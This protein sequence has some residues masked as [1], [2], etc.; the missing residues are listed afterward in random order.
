M[1]RLTLCLS[2][3]FVS[4]AGGSVFAEQT[5]EAFLETI[6]AKSRASLTVRNLDELNTQNRKHLQRDQAF[7]FK[8][9]V[10][11]GLSF[12]KIQ[13]GVDWSGTFSLSMMSLEQSDD[14]EVMM[15][16]LVL[17]VPFTD[18]ET[19]A[20][21][22]TLSKEEI[23]ARKYHFFG[24]RLN[25]FGDL[26]VTF[27]ERDLL[28]SMQQEAIEQYLESPAMS[29]VVATDPGGRLSGSDLL[30]Q[31]NPRSLDPTQYDRQTEKWIDQM[32]QGETEEHRELAKQVVR[33][34][35]QVFC[36]MK[37]E[38]GV[39]L[40]FHCNLSPDLSEEVKSALEKYHHSSSIPDLRGIPK[41]N[42]LL[43]LSKAADREQ[44][45]ALQSRATAWMVERMVQ[46]KSISNLILPYLDPRSDTFHG[47]IDEIWDSIDEARSAVY[48]NENLKED[49]LGNLL[50]ILKPESHE[51]FTEQLSSLVKFSR[52]AVYHPDIRQPDKVTEQDIR[53]LIAQLG[54][55]EFL[56][57][58]AAML[59]LKL[60]GEPALPL[61]EQS[62]NSR[63]K[64]IARRSKSLVISIRENAAHH[65]EVLIKE[66]LTALP[67]PEFVFY[68]HQREIAGYPADVLVAQWD[69]SDQLN[70]KRVQELAGPQGHEILIVHVKNEIVLF[71]GSDRQLL[72]DCLQLLKSG[73]PGLDEQR[74]T[75]AKY[76]APQRLFEAHFSMQKLARM[77][78]EA[79][80]RPLPESDPTGDYSS[81]GVEISPQH[82]IGDVSLP[83]P[84]FLLMARYFFLF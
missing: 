45:A 26:Y 32:F 21:N 80:G 38:N 17:R 37:I 23:A 30:L 8:Q 83:L 16:Q 58:K 50:V 29:T 62:V 61:L 39:Q 71:W 52:G 5:P 60:L 25:N 78:P 1:L 48:L 70:L 35:N 9:L 81:F 73:E 46:Q 41:G 53:D 75:F 69:E 43:G 36:S 28:I 65:A 66:G 27:R 6:P 77:V 64:E 63:D 59:R 10:Q 12:M 13:Q 19:M 24:K 55:Q 2:L 47:L 44:S 18:L 7:G 84:E 57:R 51:E 34:T 15:K 56:K 67:L 22:F 31:T 74:E 3:V 40:R 76:A 42:F 54:S 4:T 79:V 14:Y 11:M 33:H 49:G 68:E 72:A 82:L 20:K